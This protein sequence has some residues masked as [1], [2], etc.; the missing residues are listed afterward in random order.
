M[1]HKEVWDDNTLAEELVQATNSLAS[2]P[3]RH[4]K[5]I[6]RFL[7][8]HVYFERYSLANR[9]GKKVSSEEIGRITAEVNG[10]I[11]G[12]STL[13]LPVSTILD[14]TFEPLEVDS[15]EEALNNATERAYRDEFYDE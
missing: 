15:S 4:L 7:T 6:Q 13:N 14:G 1:A 5:K 11:L 3:N 10:K 8:L 2:I 12:F 9:V